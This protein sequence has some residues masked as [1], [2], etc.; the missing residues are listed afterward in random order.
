MELMQTN[1]RQSL[2][3]LMLIGLAACGG[4]GG[5]GGAAGGGTST[6]ASNPDAP[7]FRFNAGLPA[8][9]LS[10]QILN[11]GAFLLRV[12]QFT[13]DVAQRFAVTGSPGSVTTNCAFTG[14][15][16]LA[17][18][19]RD[20]N[21]RVSA[22]DSVAV[23]LRNCGVPILARIVTGSLRVDIT[24]V[25]A[26]GVDTGLQA[27]M[28]VLDA[29]QLTPFGG[30]NSI[31]LYPLGTLRGSLAARWSSDGLSEQLQA[32]STAEDDLRMNVL[33][34]GVESTD[35]ARKVDISR[36]TRMDAATVSTSLSYLLDVGS[37]GGSLRVRQT[38]A[39]VADVNVLPK[40]GSLEAEM[41]DNIVLRLAKTKQDGFHFLNM[42]LTQR[43]S[44][45]VLTNK[46][47]PTWSDVDGMLMY[48]IRAVLPVGLG[49][50]VASWS[51]E[52]GGFSV[53][54]SW[55]GLPADSA[56]DQACAQNTG[57]GVFAYKRADALFQRPVVPGLGATSDG[58]VLRLHFGRALA[59]NTPALQFRFRNELPSIDPD[60]PLWVVAATAVRRGAMYEIRPAEALRHGYTYILESSFDG[61]DWNGTRTFFDA[62]GRVV[63]T[64]D[65]GFAVIYTD[66]V[67]KVEL[68]LGDL[69]VPSPAMPVRLS[70]VVTARDG[71]SV[72]SYRWEQLSGAPVIFSA[73]GDAVTEV[74]YAAAGRDVAPV[75]IQLTVTDVRGAVQRVR[76]VL[77][78]GDRFASGA[79]FFRRVTGTGTYRKLT[80]QTGTGSAV[81]DAAS[82]ETR[83]RTP[84]TGEI[85]QFYN[86]ALRSPDASPLQIGLYE[87]VQL[88]T[89]P[90]LQ[91]GLSLNVECS[92]F[93]AVRGKFQVLELVRGSD[94]SIL[95][96]AVDFEQ[97]CDLPGG[98]S[99]TGSFRFNSSLPFAP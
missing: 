96:L 91:A 41:A 56:I 6:A 82:G 71:Q 8:E 50:S 2:A 75:L 70:A 72:A 33:I 61:K 27:R 28:T 18:S 89:V 4:G 65:M 80:M 31:G 47:L 16:D 76:A 53:A 5:G 97:R 51:D 25:A 60:F 37:R 30:Y 59:E 42:V 15:V 58:S 57:A 88:L 23:V 22:G 43:Q 94:S 17:F 67:L 92:N 32:V 54:T 79:L 26:A 95:R 87:N 85:P 20:G 69:V 63:A 24:E 64:G 19:D 81:Y 21:G 48:D 83:L 93:N 35:A 13:T 38:Q 34:R 1:W 49:P 55:Q 98:E 99:A 11:T 45:A 39:F 84:E 7:T 40:V 68:A 62:A 9:E 12:A 86:L 36:T 77:T 66:D 44:G 10:Q 74:S 14:S 73:P 52:G 90:G 3:L 78:V 29:L 46:D